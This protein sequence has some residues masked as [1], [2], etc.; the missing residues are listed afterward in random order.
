[1]KRSISGTLPSP[2]IMAAMGVRYSTYAFLLLSAILMFASSFQPRVAETVK[3]TVTDVLSPVV[4][5]ISYPIMQVTEVATAVS[6]LTALR[7]EN[8]RLTIENEK[9]RQWYTQA[10]F[11][12]DENQN[13][14]HL[15][16]L[17]I[18]DRL[19]FVTGQVLTDTGLAY[20]KSILVLSGKSDGIGKGDAALSG[21]GLIGRV[22]K[23]GRNVSRV[24][25]VND[26]N[27]RVPVVISGT[28]YNAI[29]KGTNTEFPLLTH[30]TE[31]ADVQIGTE[32]VTSGLGGVF[33][34][35][36]PVG[37]VS[38]DDN[39]QY[40]VRL[41]TDFNKLNYVRLVQRPIDPNLILGDL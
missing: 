14:K 30:I 33:P 11:L 4:Q 39:G 3:I 23:V 22:E 5:A 41:Y 37:K 38:L 31:N 24:L 27:S 1:M 9:L 21:D 29:M 32:I 8:L 18:D 2:N 25:L 17:Q 40:I 10:L 26:V 34:T 36:L 6:N 20:V 35:G 15:L 16:N 19:S 13:L 12:Q 28:N 7:E